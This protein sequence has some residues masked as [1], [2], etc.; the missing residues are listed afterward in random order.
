MR[1][2]KKSGGLKSTRRIRWGRNFTRKR[3]SWEEAIPLLDQSIERLS[4]KERDLVLRRYF[5]KKNFAEIAVEKGMTE[6][7]V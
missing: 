7:A 5:E 4:D 6:A 3:K 2:E 1:S